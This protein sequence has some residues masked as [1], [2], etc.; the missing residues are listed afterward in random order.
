MKYSFIRLGNNNI[1][2]CQSSSCIL[3]SMNVAAMAK[4]KIAPDSRDIHPKTKMGYGMS[5]VKR[6]V[7]RRCI[8]AVL[9][10][11]A[12]PDDQYG[13]NNHS[14]EGQSIPEPS[15]DSTADDAHVAKKHKVARLDI[16]RVSL[17]FQH[18]FLF[19][20]PANPFT[21]ATAARSH[22]S[23]WPPGQL[24]VEEDPDTGRHLRVAHSAHAALS[25][26]AN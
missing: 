14:D 17:S 6:T 8:K 24:P 22:G 25:A 13:E 11:V 12:D 7:A 2:L 21:A 23:V 15:T 18:S 5:A 4:K 10:K 3:S 16:S 26:H 9:D 20:S 1:L 19:L